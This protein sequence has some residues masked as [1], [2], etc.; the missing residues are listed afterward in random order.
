MSV[1]AT[2]PRTRSAVV[3]DAGDNLYPYRP[4][5]TA[6]PLTAFLSRCARSDHQA[7]PVVVPGQSVAPADAR[8]VQNDAPNATVVEQVAREVDVRCVGNLDDRRTGGMKIGTGMVDHRHAGW[9]SSRCLATWIRLL[10]AVPP[11][12][13]GVKVLRQS[14]L[15]FTFQTTVAIGSRWSN[16]I[17]S[18]GARSGAMIAVERV[19]PGERVVLRIVATLRRRGAP[20][21][22]GSRSVCRRAGPRVGVC[23][24]DRWVL[25]HRTIECRAVESVSEPEASGVLHQ[26]RDRVLTSAFSNSDVRPDGKPVDQ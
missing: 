13:T 24:R 17:V 16:W 4:L 9:R 20:V 18:S 1:P 6:D 8:S 23:A 21:S 19:A 14:I 22:A 26:R 25:V 7:G 10:P 11:N 2:G 3:V 12:R 5:I 15:S